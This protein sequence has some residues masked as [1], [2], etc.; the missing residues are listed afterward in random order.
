MGACLSK[1]KKR[2]T[3]SKNFGTEN[4]E[5]TNKHTV[6]NVVGTKSQRPEG[7]QSWLKHW[8]KNS[9]QVL[10]LHCPICLNF[11]E[12]NQILGAHVYISERKEKVARPK[13]FIIPACYGY[14]M[15]K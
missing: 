1:K 6:N 10:P 4:F 3:K 5:L 12:K 2:T 9:E 13:E 14:L 15:S 11:F 7:S 8:I